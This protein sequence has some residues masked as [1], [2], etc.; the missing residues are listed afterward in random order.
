LIFVE[1]AAVTMR[2]E[3]AR[4]GRNTG[5]VRPPTRPP[6]LAALTAVVLA[7]GACTGPAGPAPGARSAPPPAGSGLVW[8]QLAPAPTAR[9][10][11]AA[12]L[13]GTRV[14]VLG[15]FR[16]DGGTVA[17]VEVFDTATGRW[18]HGPDLPVPVNHAMAAG[19]DGI[20][21]LFGGYTP[22]GAPSAAAFR[23][24]PGGW[25]AAA[26]MP[27]GRAAGTAV[28]Q[29]GNVYLAGGVG[30]GGLAAQML[31]Y[32]VTGDRW[33]TAPGPP[34][35]REHLG[36]AGFG[37]LVYTI[38]G[39][40]GG[41]DP[42][43]AA[44]EV[45]D[46]GTGRWTSLPGLPTRRGGLAGA[47][48]CNGLVL[49]VGGEGQAAFAEA[50]AFDVR[51]GTWRALPPLPTPRHGLGA[52]A[53]GTVLYTFAGGPRP[54]LHV[55]DVT[56]AIDLASLGACPAAATRTGTSAATWAATWPRRYGRA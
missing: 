11:V 36:G 4:P 38:G 14:Y 31:V 7:G 28:V 35:R 21:Y 16:A 26:G 8:H 56:E 32:D 50:E 48:T 6:V 5:E 17:T 41:V 20:V 12:A 42:N 45:Y 10:E 2:D 46:P 24:E 18:D 54:G 51:A 25:R 23:L 3:V 22:G 33:S 13:A 37:G 15:G 49:A 39:R 30:P 52:V 27:Q 43:L 47:A 29:N 53:L 44:F 9:T 19:V 34:T 40:T 55:A 1:N